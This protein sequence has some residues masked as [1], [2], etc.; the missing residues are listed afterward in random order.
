MVNRIQK[1]LFLCLLI[2]LSTQAQSLQT[3]TLRPILNHPPRWVLKVAPM[4]LFDLD[5]T[6]QVAAERLLVGRHSL[7]AE[8]GY[9]IQALNLYS[10]RRE[11]YEN[12]EVWRGRFEWRRYSG[13]Y[14]LYRNPHFSEPPIGRYF[15]VETFFKQLT[16]LNNMAVGRD[17]VDGNCAYFQRGIYPMYRTVW[18]AHAKIGRQYVLEMPSDNRF[19]LDLFIGIGFRYLSPYR[20]NNSTRED[21]FRSPDMWF[22]NTR[23]RQGGLRPSISLGVKL[24]YVL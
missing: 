13:R 23:I 20:F 4:A 15:A 17:C 10:Y 18:G 7:Q 9:G 12:F 5:N 1:S 3:D 2:S 24:G 22:G 6:I 14:R 11:E 21:V 19:L 16:V 8:F